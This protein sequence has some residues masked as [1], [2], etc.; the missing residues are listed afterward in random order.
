MKIHRRV[1]FALLASS[2]ALAASSDD[3]ILS[4]SKKE[5]GVQVAIDICF[6]DNIA[7]RGELHGLSESFLMALS[8]TSGLSLRT[9]LQSRDEGRKKAS[10]NL[11]AF[12]RQCDAIRSPLEK[13]V[14]DRARAQL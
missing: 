13:A 7:V 5:G 4:L 1:A 12:L 10:L 11:E 6:K 14:R 8:G 3:A 2:S 9:I